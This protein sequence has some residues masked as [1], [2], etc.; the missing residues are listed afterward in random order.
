[1]PTRRLV[2][3]LHPLLSLN[4]VLLSCQLHWLKDLVLIE[5]FCS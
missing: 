4:N 1:V 3:T 5:L 2:C